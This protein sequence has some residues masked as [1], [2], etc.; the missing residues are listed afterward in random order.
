MLASRKT[1]HYNDDG[2]GFGVGETARMVEKT[3]LLELVVG[4]TVGVVLLALHNRKVGE[5]FHRHVQDRP[6]RRLLLATIGFFV[7]FAMA[8][9]MA[10]EASHN[11]GPFHYVYVRGT[12]IHHLVW[13]ILLLLAVG[14]C[15]LIEVGTGAK[16]SSLLASRLMSLLYGVG[17]A[18]T[19]DEFALWLHLQEGV[20]WTRQDLIS[21]DA[22]ILFGAALLIGLWGREFLRAVGL[23]IWRSRPK[24][25]KR[26]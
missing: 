4:A 9:A 17:A 21:L 11:A 18:L 23:E 26:K 7:T 8:R 20:Y 16:A 25:R 3:L 1:G 12:H 22:V 19:L 5:L 24:A 10:Y 15:W 13:G 14:F 6:Q 2:V